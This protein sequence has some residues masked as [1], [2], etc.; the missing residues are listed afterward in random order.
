M[1]GCSSWAAFQ[2]RPVWR[3]RYVLIEL[4][5]GDST[6]QQRTAHHDEDAALPVAPLSVDGRNLVL[7]L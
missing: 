2:P 1:L 3:F 6:Y 4:V 7:D 5:F